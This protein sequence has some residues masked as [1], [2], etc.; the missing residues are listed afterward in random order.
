MSCLFAVT[1]DLRAS[2]ALRTI[3]SAGTNPPISSMMTSASD[4]STASTSSVQTTLAGTQ[5]CFF[6]ATFRLQMWVSFTDSLFVSHRIFATDRPTVQQPIRA[7]RQT[8][9]RPWPGDALPPAVEVF[10]TA[11]DEN[12]I[13]Y[14]TCEFRLTK[15]IFVSYVVVPRV[16]IAPRAAKNLQRTLVHSGRH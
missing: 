12:G 15:A 3:C 16:R 4:F 8:E 7:T 11:L 1:T 14:H 5:S 6:R 2:S 13:H 9:S 10:V